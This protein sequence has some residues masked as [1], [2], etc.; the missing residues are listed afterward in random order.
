MVTTFIS[1]SMTN[2]GPLF[3]Y[4]INPMLISDLNI[5]VAYI[6]NQDVNFIRHLMPNNVFPLVQSHG[7]PLSQVALDK[8]IWKHT[9]NKSSHSHRPFKKFPI[10]TQLSKM[11][12]V[13]K[14]KKHI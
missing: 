3:D 10:R 1:S 11:V 8:I 4:V 7:P 6:F 12:Q 14:F 2:L 13:L 9:V 5:F